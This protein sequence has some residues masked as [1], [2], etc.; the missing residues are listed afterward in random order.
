[1]EPN[2]PGS[3]P[4]QYPFF[5]SFCLFAFL[6]CFVCLFDLLLIVVVVF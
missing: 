4:A 2:V 6:F 5:F 1:M 3:D